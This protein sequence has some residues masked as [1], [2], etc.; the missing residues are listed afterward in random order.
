MTEDL[1]EYKHSLVERVQQQLNQ[2]VGCGDTLFF[3]RFCEV[4]GPEASYL[5]APLGAACEPCSF[6]PSAVLTFL[7][8][9]SLWEKARIAAECIG[10]AA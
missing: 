1:L 9:S 10:P 6:N 4:G 2:Q 3:L 5:V 8:R 7:A